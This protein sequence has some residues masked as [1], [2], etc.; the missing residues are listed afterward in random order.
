MMNNSSKILRN[1]AAAVFVAVASANLYLV[2]TSVY[3]TVTTLTSGMLSGRLN[4]ISFMSVLKA[5]LDPLLL[6]LFNLVLSAILA[7]IILKSKNETLAVRIFCF[8]NAAY[9]LYLFI[10]SGLGNPTVYINDFGSTLLILAQ[11]ILP[12]A[13]AVLYR[14]TCKKQCALWLSVMSVALVA[15]SCLTYAVTIY[16]L[17]A[18]AYLT[19]YNFVYMFVLPLITYLPL[20]LICI[21]KRID[22]QKEDSAI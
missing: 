10:V 8:G 20:L 6:N 4:T 12:S 21:L 15:V 13:I 11:I 22:C 7:V 16:R 1:T 9:N 2:G 18:Y 19:P 14:K 17:N 3:S 5:I